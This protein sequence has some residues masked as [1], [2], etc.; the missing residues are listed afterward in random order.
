[1][2]LGTLTNRATTLSSLEPYHPVAR[3][4]DRLLLADRLGALQLPVGT[5]EDMERESA[6]PV[7]S[8]P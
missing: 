1:M 2:D 7:K 3:L 4:T 5:E 6:A 8:L